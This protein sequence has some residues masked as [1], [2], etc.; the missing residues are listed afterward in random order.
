MKKLASATS[1]IL[2]PFS[3]TPVVF[4]ILTYNT[5][6]S[7][8]NHSHY[9]ITLLFSTIIPFITFLVLK[10]LGFQNVKVYLGSWGEWGNNLKLPIE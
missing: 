1:I 3:I 4:T 2:H 5:N 6:L 10:K 8:V 7:E 9:L